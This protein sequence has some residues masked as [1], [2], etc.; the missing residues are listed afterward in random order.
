MTRHPLDRGS[1]EEVYV[2]HEDG[3]QFVLML[4]D[5]ALQV[6][7][8]RADGPVVRS[9]R[10]VRQRHLS[11]RRVLH[12]EHDLKQRIAARVPLGLELVDQLLE[13]QVL[14]VVRFECHLTH[15][16]QEFSEGR[17]AREIGAH[18]EAVHEKSLPGPRAR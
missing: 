13:G 15:T 2:V 1:V 7:A 16:P 12:R 11:H 14:V 9:D 6:E 10:Q 17:V 18:H 8:G 5:V 4:V 3:V